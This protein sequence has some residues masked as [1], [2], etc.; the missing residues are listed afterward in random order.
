MK[1][2]CVFPAEKK[3]T[4]F[5]SKLS[6]NAESCAVATIKHKDKVCCLEKEKNHAA[7]SPKQTFTALLCSTVRP[8]P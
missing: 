4:L 7:P 5:I 3:N 8:A 6:E 1:A 2:G